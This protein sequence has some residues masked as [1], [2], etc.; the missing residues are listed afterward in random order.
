MTR[1]NAYQTLGLPPE[2]S[3]ADVKKAYRALCLELHPDHNPDADPDLFLE[4]Q[5]AY[6]TLTSKPKKE[7][8]KIEEVFCAMFSKH[9]LSSDPLRKVYQELEGDRHVMQINRRSTEKDI[10]NLERSLEQFLKRNKGHILLETIQEL[11]EGRIGQ[12]KHKLEMLEK[13]LESI[14]KIKEFIKG[15]KSGENDPSASTYQDL[16]NKLNAPTRT[17]PG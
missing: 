6:E 1:E 9:L 4:I 2:A 7:V 17:F 5:E 13:N 10:K 8:D 15:L 16:L 11:Y 14:H 12:E 3:L